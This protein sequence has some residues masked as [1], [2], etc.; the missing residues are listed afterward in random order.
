M[1]RPRKPVAPKTV[2]MRGPIGLGGQ[3]LQQTSIRIL[4][5]ELASSTNSNLEAYIVALL[6]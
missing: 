5:V 4:E 3:Y 2:T 1:R 6:W